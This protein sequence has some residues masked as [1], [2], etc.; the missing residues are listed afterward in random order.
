MYN[1]IVRSI[2]VALSNV[3][4]L[5]IIILITVSG[6]CLKRDQILMLASIYCVHVQVLIIHALIIK[7]KMPNNTHSAI[8]LLH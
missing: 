4:H 1:N 6:A 3:C 7:T 5:Q 2:V 8:I